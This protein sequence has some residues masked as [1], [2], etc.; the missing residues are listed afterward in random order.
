M[1]EIL[2]QTKRY[3]YIDT[4]FY[5]SVFLSNRNNI[6]KSFGENSKSI[7]FM[8]SLAKPMQASILFDSNIIKD[9]DISNKELAIFSG[10]HAGSETHIKLLK[11]ILKKHSLKLSDLSIS[12]IEPL[13]KRKFNGRKTK[14]HNNCSGKHIMMLLNCKY[15]GYDYNYTDKNHPVQKKIKQKQELLTGYKSNIVTYD[16]CSTPL[17]G[18]P[19]EN[20]IEG[21]FNLIEKHP[22][23]INTIIKNHYIYG[24]Y[25]RFDSEI[26]KLSKGKLFAKVGA[27]GLVIVYNFQKNEILLI[28]LAQDNNDIRR[29]IT[30]DFLNKINWLKYNSDKNVYN[31]KK[32]IVAKYEFSLR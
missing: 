27:G 30:L 28:K 5:G 18:L 26:I 24:G 20:I 1:H 15:F 21:Y 17:W 9:Y 6:Y 32:Q 11:N 31:Q 4:C 19:Y 2:L 8:R 10:S 13:D 12:E 16:G 14:L 29:L 23:L 25:N 22:E 3:D 7:C